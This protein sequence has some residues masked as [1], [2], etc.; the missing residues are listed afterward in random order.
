MA[1]K[2]DYVI[3]IDPGISTG[4]CKFKEGL[5]VESLTLSPL[6]AISLV[7]DSKDCLIVIE[8]SRMQSYLFT[9]DKLNEQERLKIARNVGMVDLICKLIV[10]TAKE[11]GVKLVT[12]SPQS[13]GKKIK[14]NKELEKLTGLS[15]SCN[16]QHERD[17]FKL[18]YLYRNVK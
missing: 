6:N 1:I 9:G 7:M 4:V 2:Y 14:S 13:K 3:G 12:I 5:L 10:D 18:A 17:A 11:V 16:N 15:V 8:D